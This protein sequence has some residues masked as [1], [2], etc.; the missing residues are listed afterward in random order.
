MPLGQKISLVSTWCDKGPLGPTSFEPLQKVQSWKA[1]ISILREIVILVCYHKFVERIN[2]GYHLSFFL[3]LSILSLGISKASTE[4]FRCTH[5]GFSS[6]SEIE[7]DIDIDIE[8][9]PS[10]SSNPNVRIKGI[11]FLGYGGHAGNGSSPLRSMAQVMQLHMDLSQVPDPLLSNPIELSKFFEPHREASVQSYLSHEADYL[12]YGS[13]EGLTPQEPGVIRP[14][15]LILQRNLSNSPQGTTLHARLNEE[16]LKTSS[17]LDR[18][19]GRANHFVLNSWQ[20]N[21]FLRDTVERGNFRLSQCL[22]CPLLVGS[23]PA[24]LPSY[25]TNWNNRTP[26]TLTQGVLEGCE[27]P[28]RPSPQPCHPLR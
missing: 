11:R 6:F 26:R 27:S 23:N 10:R 16:K 25:I 24:T 8:R 1:Q 2:Y 19:I 3:Y 17:G 4:T 18:N 15:P 13:R 22:K 28:N 14:Y 9:P 21:L 7:I 5:A 12:A 20:M